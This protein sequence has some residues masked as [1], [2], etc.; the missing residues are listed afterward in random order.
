MTCGFSKKFR[1]RFAGFSEKQKLRFSEFQ[2]DRVT[3]Y[4]KLY[5]WATTTRKPTLT[6]L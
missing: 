6:N 5:D 4:Q 2:M 1:P 3:E